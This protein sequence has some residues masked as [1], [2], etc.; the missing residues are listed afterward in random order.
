MLMI[1]NET[2]PWVTLVVVMVFFVVAAIT[3]RMIGSR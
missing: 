1:A 3:S 2:H